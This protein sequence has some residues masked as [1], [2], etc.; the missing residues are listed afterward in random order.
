LRTE[1]TRARAFCCLARSLEHSPMRWPVSQE[2]LRDNPEGKSTPKRGGP[3]AGAPGS[4]VRGWVQRPRPCPLCCGATDQSAR[5]RR[6]PRAGAGGGICG[7]GM[8]YSEGPRVSQ[9]LG[10]AGGQQIRP[11]THQARR[12]RLMWVL[13]HKFCCPAACELLTARGSD[14]ANTER[15]RSRTPAR[16]PPPRGERP[17]AAAAASVGQARSGGGGGAAPVD[18]R[19]LAPRAARRACCKVRGMARDRGA[20]RGGGAGLPPRV[21]TQQSA[22]AVQ[23]CLCLWII[24]IFEMVRPLVRARKTY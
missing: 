18:S 1:R 4:H 10:R 2:A 13:Q 15:P 22:A 17:H 9:G 8:Q 20:A 16:R 24:A 5:P 12:Q 21:A 6:R 3:Q 7:C 11:R 19:Q 23:Q 14:V